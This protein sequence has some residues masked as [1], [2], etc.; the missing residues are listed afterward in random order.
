MLRWRDYRDSHNPDTPCQEV[1]QQ[2]KY[3]VF[4][5]DS[6]SCMSMRGQKPAG[7]KLRRNGHYGNGTRRRNR[8]SCFLSIPCIFRYSLRYISLP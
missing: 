6:V 5:E 2:G 4:P 1:S 7:E 3:Q 8:L